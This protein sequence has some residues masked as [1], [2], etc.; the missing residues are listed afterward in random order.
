[1]SKVLQD[2]YILTDSGTTIWSRVFD[3]KINAQMFGA[4]MSAINKFAEQIT[5]SGI[6]NFELIKKQFV[7]IKKKDLLFIGNAGNKVKQKKVKNELN[8]IS[9]KFFELYSDQL[10]RIKKFGDISL[11]SDFED[12]IEPSLEDTINKFQ[13]AF[14]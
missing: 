8:R 9:E 11:L 5:E 12:H 4:V 13:K 3:P 1:M 10:H 2:I 7:I 14:W 6:T